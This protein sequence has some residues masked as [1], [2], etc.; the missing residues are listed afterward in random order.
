[1]NEMKNKK[2][3]I[4]CLECLRGEDREN[5]ISPLKHR[6]A[7]GKEIAVPEKMDNIGL[8]FSLKNVL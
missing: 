4:I 6:S 8:I 1:M 3:L 7:W 2:Y 5:I